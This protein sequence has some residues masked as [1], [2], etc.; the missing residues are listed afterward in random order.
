LRER[1]EGKE[2]IPGGEGEDSVREG[3]VRVRMVSKEMRKGEACP[4][5]TSKF[6]GRA[7]MKN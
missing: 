4:P 2:K 3:R 6:E 1:I 5:R 7:E